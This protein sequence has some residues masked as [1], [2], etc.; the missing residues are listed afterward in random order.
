MAASSSA[1]TYLGSAKGGW[2]RQVGWRHI[3]GLLALFFALFPILFVISAAFNP[4]GTLSSTELIPSGA[5]LGNFER[6]IQ[7]TRFGSWF[8]NTLIIGTTSAVSSMFVSACAAYAFSRYRFRGRR[9]GL[10]SLLLVQMFPQFLAAVA[11]YLMFTTISDLYPAIGF[12]TRWALILLYLGGALSVNTW[13]MKGFLDSIPKELDESAK[14]DGATHSQIFFG[15]IFPLVTPI[16]AITGLIAFIWAVNEFLLASIFLT[17]L[18]SQTLAVGLYGLVA[19]ER[20]NNFGVYCAGSVLTAIPT[21]TLFQFLQRYIVS[22]LTS[23]AVK[24]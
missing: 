15:I 5:S 7:G 10:L 6:I 2:F 4:L 23:G 14:V 20:N 18:D 1:P 8:L 3:V 9:M 17:D 12:N 16:L 21:V 11:L 24:G 22:G 19:G 13:L